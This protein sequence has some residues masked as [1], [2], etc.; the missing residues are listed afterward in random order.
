MAKIVVS[1]SLD[2][3]ATSV[4]YGTVSSYSA[5]QISPRQQPQI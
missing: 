3:T 5:S 4:F 1:H 2:M